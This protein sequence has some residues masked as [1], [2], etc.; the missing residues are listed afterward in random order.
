MMQKNIIIKRGLPS[1]D[2]EQQA[3]SATKKRFRDSSMSNFN[4]PATMG[5][6][7]KLHPDCTADCVLSSGQILYRVLVPSS[8]YV[9]SN[10][11]RGGKVMPP[12]GTKVLIVF[13]D[14][15]I[16]GACIVRSYFSVEDSRQDPFFAEG[17]ENQDQVVD[18]IWTQ[19]YDQA[20][21]KRVLTD[22]V[23][24]LTIDPEAEEWSVV[25]WSGNNIAA[26][27]DGMQ[28]VDANNN[29]V[30]M[31]SSKIVLNGNVEILQ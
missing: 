4:L 24:T 2:M 26:D 28:I 13:P 3:I 11:I 15:I 22:G 7:R 18:E 8:T 19:T 21:G 6:I 23:F 14:G 5:R 29:T 31:E 25:D 1:R 10:P 12:I 16:E 9:T 17:E 30:S 27:S 20:T